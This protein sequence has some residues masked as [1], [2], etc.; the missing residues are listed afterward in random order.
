MAGSRWRDRGDDH[1]IRRLLPLRSYQ[2]G[3]PWPALSPCFSVAEKPCATCTADSPTPTIPEVA[4]SFRPGPVRHL[5]RSTSHP[6]L[7]S[8]S[9]PQ[10]L[11]RGR[12]TERGKSVPTSRS[13]HETWQHTPSVTE[14]PRAESEPWHHIGSEP[15]LQRLMQRSVENM[16]TPKGLPPT[17]ALNSAVGLHHLA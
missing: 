3:I 9:H 4:G 7:R 11:V 8:A 13:C 6:L 17:D 15:R 1:S 10:Q 14:I 5:L 12:W 2:C 16:G